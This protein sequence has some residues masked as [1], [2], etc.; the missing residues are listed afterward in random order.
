MEEDNDDGV[1]DTLDDLTGPVENDDVF[2]TGDVH[3]SNRDLDMAEVYWGDDPFNLGSNFVGSPFM[4]FGEFM[5]IDEWNDGR[6][7]MDDVGK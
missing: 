2:D 3:G 1:I 5:N 4:S 7:V 6:P